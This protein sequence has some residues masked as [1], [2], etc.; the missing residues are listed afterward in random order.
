MQ[1]QYSPP[2]PT[3]D[4][5]L[6]C[7]CWGEAAA[8]LQSQPVFYP[9]DSL[10]L[11]QEAVAGARAPLPSPTHILRILSASSYGSQCYDSSWVPNCIPGMTSHDICFPSLTQP[12]SGTPPALRAQSEASQSHGRSRYPSPCSSDTQ[13]KYIFLGRPPAISE[14]PNSTVMKH[15][16]SPN[17]YFS[18]T[19]PSLGNVRE[20]QGQLTGRGLVEET[21]LHT[22]RKHCEHYKLSGMNRVP[23]ELQRNTSCLE[24]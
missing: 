22:G 2:H 16:H 14:P 18:S 7:R 13:L 8:N 24:S 12:V 9:K 10:V 11:R 19:R 5:V 3:V 4:G 23:W 21:E 20:I 17:K 15:I 6:T 1:T